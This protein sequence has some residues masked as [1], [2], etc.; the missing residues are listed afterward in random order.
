[1]HEFFV[2]DSIVKA[3]L[4]EAEKH[5]GLK[6]VKAITLEVGELTFLNPDQLHFAFEST[7]RNSV[8]KGA[9]LVIT[10]SPAR[11]KCSECDYEGPMNN[12]ESDGAHYLTPIF[13]CPECSKPVKVLEGNGCSIKTMKLEI[14]DDIDDAMVADVDDDGDDAI[15]D[16]EKVEEN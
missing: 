5:P 3:A 10:I 9:E 8:L 16:K 7:T 4:K 14:N 2:M 1:M 15:Q 6:R 11:V 12:V 13:A